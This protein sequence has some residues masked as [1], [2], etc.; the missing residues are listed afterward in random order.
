MSLTILWATLNSIWFYFNHNVSII[1]KSCNPKLYY[2][3]SALTTV[4]YQDQSACWHNHQD[5]IKNR[6][7]GKNDLGCVH[8]EVSHFPS[9]TTSRY[10]YSP[11]FVWSM[12]FHHF[13][14][15]TLV[16]ARESLWSLQVC[17]WFQGSDALVQN[18]KASPTPVPCGHALRRQRYFILS[19]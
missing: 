9:S 1:L 12:P 16:A 15:I 6:E 18:I 19:H 11:F 13:P 14:I 8:S 3:N 10:L 7:R 2:F 5:S 17:V 4:L